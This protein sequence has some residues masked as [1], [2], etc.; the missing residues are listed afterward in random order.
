MLPL[1]ELRAAAVAAAA[2]MTLFGRPTSV[3]FRR[4]HFVQLPRVIY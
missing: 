1:G 4:I 3:S 2:V